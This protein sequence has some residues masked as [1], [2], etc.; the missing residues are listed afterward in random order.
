MTACAKG[1][2]RQISDGLR[3]EKD[4]NL[5]AVSGG[6][7]ELMAKRRSVHISMGKQNSVQV[8]RFRDYFAQNNY[9]GYRCTCQVPPNAVMYEAA[10]CHI[11]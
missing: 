8:Y 2:A 1:E 11:I 7:F 6:K 5:V 10:F 3:K 9:I 4:G